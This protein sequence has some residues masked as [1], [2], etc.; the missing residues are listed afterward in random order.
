VQT[1]SLPESII[2]QGRFVEKDG[3]KVLILPPHVLQQ[4]QENMAKQQQQQQALLANNSSSGMLS[5][6]S[7]LSTGHGA[8]KPLF[9]PSSENDKFELTDDYIQQTIKDAL[10]AG[11][12]T[13]ELEE[14]LIKQL[15]T[16]GAVADGLPAGVG[17]TKFRRS[18]GA[19]VSKVVMCQYLYPFTPTAAIVLRYRQPFFRIPSNSSVYLLKKKLALVPVAGSSNFKIK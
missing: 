11:N 16:S 6:S 18:A 4:H 7:R 19:K 9:S 12:L 2:Q 15:E 8:S 14:K 1:L 17:G 3:K 13:P 10:K 5:P